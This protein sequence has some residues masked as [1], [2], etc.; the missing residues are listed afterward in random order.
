[1]RH[2]QIKPVIQGIILLGIVVLLFSLKGVSSEPNTACLCPP[3]ASKIGKVTYDQCE[4]FEKK[5]GWSDKKACEECE[6]KYCTSQLGVKSPDGDPVY[7]KYKCEWKTEHPCSCP[8]PPDSGD[9]NTEYRITKDCE[10]K[11]AFYCAESTCK[12][13]L[14]DKSSGNPV[15]GS[16]DIDVAC[17]DGGSQ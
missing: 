14:F 13:R 7:K 4:T 15:D 16:K 9:P 17:T 3:E 6:K 5:D 2:P 11:N 10:P 1:M 8:P 12:M